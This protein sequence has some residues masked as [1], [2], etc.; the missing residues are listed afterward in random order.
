MTITLKKCTS[1]KNHLTRIFETGEGSTATHTGTL[2]GSASLTDPVIQIPAT[3]SIAEFNYIEIPSFERKY[4]ITDLPVLVNGMW[5]IH[6][7]VDAIGTWLTE[8]LDCEALADDRET[9]P[10]LY[11]DHGNIFSDDRT[12][13]SVQRLKGIKHTPYATDQKDGEGHDTGKGYAYIDPDRWV[14]ILIV[15]GPGAPPEP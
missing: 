14:K 3:E 6:A 15:A 4:F 5:E 1:E 7:H 11:V 13:Y 10:N 8:I 12:I 2:R 9:N